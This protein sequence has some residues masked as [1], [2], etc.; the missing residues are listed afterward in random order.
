MKCKK[1]YA[2]GGEVPVDDK[3]KDKADRREN[4]A[5]R[6]ENRAAR[7]NRRSSSEPVNF[8]GSTPSR[9]KEKHTSVKQPMVC[10]AE[11]SNK[12]DAPKCLTKG[13]RKKR[14]KDFLKPSGLLKGR[15]V[16]SKP[17]E[18]EERIPNST[19][20]VRNPRYL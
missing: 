20:N 2:G 15:I 6:A 7:V 16:R 12:S 13:G 8:P 3:K 5:A 11:P 4:R 14:I 17:E 18:E 1:K 9:Q 19:G 10:E